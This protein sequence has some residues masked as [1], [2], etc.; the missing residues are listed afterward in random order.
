MLISVIIPVYNTSKYLRRCIDSVVGQTYKDLEIIIVNDGSTDNSLSI[1]KEYNDSRITIIDKENGGL[2]SARNSGIASANGE[3]IL[4]VDSDD[5]IELNYIEDIV[6]YA[7]KFNL[8]LVVSDFLQEDELGNTNYQ[9]DMKLGYGELISNKEYIRRIIDEFSIYPCVWNKLIRRSL[10]IDHNIRHP[11]GISMGEDLFVTPKLAY[12]SNRIGKLNKAYYHYIYN[13]NSISKS[14]NISNK[15]IREM[16]YVV[17]DLDKYLN[18]Y[19]LLNLYKFHVGRQIK[20]L[21]NEYIMN[22]L[23]EEIIRYF[24]FIYNNNPNSSQLRNIKFKL[25]LNK[26]YNKVRIKMYKIA[27]RIVKR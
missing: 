25:I 2:S 5:Y 12:N 8:D 17:R 1:L 9:I 3:Y 19:N 20:A 10:Y 24:N 13:P 16:D 6:N 23:N 4:H 27:K 18:E 21:P 15:K 22:E 26:E 11:E 14:K 7:N